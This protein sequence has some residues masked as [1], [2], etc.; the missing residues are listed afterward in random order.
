VNRQIEGDEPATQSTTLTTLSSGSYSNYG[1]VSFITKYIETY[2]DPSE[3]IAWNKGRHSM[4]AGIQYR[5]GQDNGI[6]VSG[7]GPN[8]V[9]TFSPGTPLLA[10]IPSTDGG[11][12]ILAGTGSPSDK[13]SFMEGAD[14]NYERS[15]PIPPSTVRPRAATGRC[16][17]VKSLVRHSAWRRPP[18]TLNGRSNW[19]RGSS[20]DANA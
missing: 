9:Y 20:F 5:Y 8:G 1:T 10:S 4:T 14:Y 17:A 16:R 11:P 2:Y 13:V 15:T 7:E 18:L 3:K 19:A 12:E 6:G